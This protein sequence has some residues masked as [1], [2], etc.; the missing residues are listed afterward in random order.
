MDDLLKII[1]NLCLNFHQ[2]GSTCIDFLDANQMAFLELI[3]LRQKPSKTLQE[4][5]D[6]IVKNNDKP[7]YKDTELEFFHEFDNTNFQSIIDIVFDK[8]NGRLE[9][10]NNPF[11]SVLRAAQIFDTNDWPAD[12]HQLAGY[13]IQQLQYLENHFQQFLDHI[14][15]D[16]TRLEEECTS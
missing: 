14:G 11:K 1:T 6:T 5:L 13:G 15:C 4:V 2:N 7:Y 16:R 3:Q 9:N 12:R 8:I 10:P